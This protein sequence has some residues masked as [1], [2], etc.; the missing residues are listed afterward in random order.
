M[1]WS[2]WVAL[3]SASSILAFPWMTPEGTD[4]LLKHPEARKEIE[5]RLKSVRDVPAKS[6]KARQ[7]D[8][9]A[10]YGV[11]TVLDGTLSAVLDPVLGLIP[12]NEAVKD[13]KRFPERLFTPPTYA[14]YH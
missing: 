5:K 13:S 11:T 14:T 9:G 10:L 1:R 2:I 7:L 3:S 4:A 6:I 12:T 8:T